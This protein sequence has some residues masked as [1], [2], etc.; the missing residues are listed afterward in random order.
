MLI[1]QDD[2]ALSTAESH[3]GLLPAGEPAPH[4]ERAHAYSGH[5]CAGEG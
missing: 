3:V 4:G 1:D 2:P 5:V